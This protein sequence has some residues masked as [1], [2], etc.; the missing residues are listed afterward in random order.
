MASKDFTV[1]ELYSIYGKTLTETQS[2]AVE[3]YFG[4]DLSLG[5]I[6]QN[7]GISRQSVKDTLSCAE[8]QL[9]A[10]EENLRF[11]SKKLRVRELCAKLKT[12]L[13][14]ENFSCDYLKND[15]A[16]ENLKFSGKKINEEN[17]AELLASILDVLED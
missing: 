8:K 11:Y 10:L 2:R 13:T 12:L 4:L 16:S 5:E 9:F 3:D 17:A 14:S 7:R 6:A 1:Y 15:Y